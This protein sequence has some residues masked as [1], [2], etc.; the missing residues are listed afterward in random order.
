MLHIILRCWRD[1][2]V[3]FIECKILGFENRTVFL[4]VLPVFEG[5][6]ASLSLDMGFL[7]LNPSMSTG[8]EDDEQ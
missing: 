6:P 2:E 5:L 4:T 8:K 1:K 3:K 7:G